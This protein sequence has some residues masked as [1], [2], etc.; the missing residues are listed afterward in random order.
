MKANASF[1]EKRPARGHRPV[2][3]TA[4]PPGTPLSLKLKAPAKATPQDLLDLAMRKWT[5][6]ERFDIGKMAQELGVSRATVFRWVGSRELLYGEVLSNLF[7]AALQQAMSE[8]EGNGPDYIADVSHRLMST[9][10]A[11]EPLRMFVQQDTE[12]AMR[13]LMSKSSTVEQR[14]ADS[15]RRALEEQ[16]RAGQIRP[17]M[18]LSDLAYLI[19]RIGESFLYRDAITGEP[20]DIGSATTAIRILV[21]AKG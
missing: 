21:A 2:K 17:A 14:S 13:I 11:H 1:R 7:D 20:P 12:Y 10:V 6:G 19:V 4:P 8:A 15:V 16:A 9:M 3:R 5:E 18:K